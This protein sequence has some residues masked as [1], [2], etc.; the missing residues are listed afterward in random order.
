MDFSSLKSSSEVL[1]KISPRRLSAFTMKTIVY[2]LSLVLFL[3]AS[4]VFYCN[5]EGWTPEIAFG[6]AIVTLST[7]GTAFFLPSSFSFAERH[8]A[9]LTYH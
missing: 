8:K 9:T 7:V 3:T 2:L 5:Y 1:E 6:F 4:A